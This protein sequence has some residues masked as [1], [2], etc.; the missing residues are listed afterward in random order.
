MPL[1]ALSLLRSCAAP[2]RRRGA[3]WRTFKGLSA[4]A[5]L[6]TLVAPGM[7]AA[8]V[9]ATPALA[10]PA[11][12]PVLEPLAMQQLA[13]GVFV[14]HGLQQ[15]WAPANAGNVANVAFI[16][17]SRCVAVVDSGGS[18]QVG[19][20]LRLAVA[21]ATP[22]PV[23]LVVT[24][25]AHPDHLLGLAAFVP[26]PGQGAAPALAAHIRLSAALGARERSYRQAVQREFGQTLP[27]SAIVY[28]TLPVQD[29][30]DFDLGERVLR[31]QAW[32]T[33]HTDN[34]LTVF[35]LASRT[36]FTGDLVFGGHL[37]VLD[38]RL[39]GWL[40]VMDQ[41]QQMGARRV[42]PGHGA[43]SDDLAVLLA[44]QRRYLLA[45]RDDVRAALRQRLTLAQAVDR[46]GVAPAAT[47]TASPAPPWLLT[48]LFHKRNVTA[49]FAELEW[50]D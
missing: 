6:G 38:G 41:L 47:G 39:L 11:A 7:L 28:P 44:P 48:E 14:Q 15:P 25:H 10:Q 9:S 35:D 49:A 32:P 50:E 23:C 17:G 2:L 20:R 8:L 19:Q 5:G 21:Q 33:A 13:P 24:T 29:T 18:L 4:R 27:D 45:L 30:L 31:L 34:D 26:A 1:S 3:V 37:P 16:V 42:V 40:A 46:I 36:L 43:T 12:T 22:L